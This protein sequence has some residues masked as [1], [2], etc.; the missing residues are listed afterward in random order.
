MVHLPLEQ[1]L[2]WS[3]GSSCRATFKNPFRIT[4]ILV[5]SCCSLWWGMLVW[6]VSSLHQRFLAHHGPYTSI[7]NT[8]AG[9]SKK[10][11]SR[12]SPRRSRCPPR[13]PCSLH[14]S[15]V[16]VQGGVRRA[17][18]LAGCPCVTSIIGNLFLTQICSAGEARQGVNPRSRPSAQARPAGAC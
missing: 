16:G 3:H 10:Q 18:T 6:R 15:C 17:C 1:R 5:A 13:A 4:R 7:Y 8:E 12:K 14:A 2:A 9:C 11:S